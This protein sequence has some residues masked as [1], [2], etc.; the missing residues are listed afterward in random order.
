MKCPEC[1]AELIRDVRMLSY[2]YKGHTVELET[3]GD[4][5]PT[6]GEAVLDTA[7]WDRQDAL[8]QEFQRYVNADVVSP[9]FIASVRTK[10]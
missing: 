1:G 5:C 8:M 7:E 9:E 10:A 2:T 3:R 6:C 4:F